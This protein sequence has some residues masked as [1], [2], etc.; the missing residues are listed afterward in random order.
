M[1]E[2]KGQF[3]E[4][5]VRALANWLWMGS[6]PALCRVESG[7]HGYEALAEFQLSR[8]KC[9]LAIE[10]CRVRSGRLSSAI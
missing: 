2:A 3:P 6:L 7:A 8:R 5:S 10:Y 1:A 4:S 9:Q